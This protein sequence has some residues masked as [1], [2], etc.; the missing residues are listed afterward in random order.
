MQQKTQ[1]LVLAGVFI[2]LGLVLPIA[3][4]GVGMAGNIFLPMHIP[5]L[6][7][8]LICGSSLGGLVGLLVPLLS[9]L[10]F[11]MPPLYPVAV[12]MACELIIYGVVAGF[13]AKKTSVIIA[14]L[15]AM[16]AGRVALGLAQMLLLGF[17]T[18]GFSWQM[19]LSGAFVTALPGII[20][21]LIIIPLLI[22]GLKRAN[23]RIN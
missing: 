6:L 15:G 18:K 14:L 19:F 8:G 2:A 16:L 7:C 20:I 9:S 23:L 3:F 13:L 4:H 17:G 22:A 21:Q 10:F 11:G 12:Y 1:K 5:V